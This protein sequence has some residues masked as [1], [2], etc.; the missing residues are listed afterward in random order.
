VLQG[1]IEL[2]N[3][4]VFAAAIVKK[5]RYWPNHINGHGI[6]T[7]FEGRDVGNTTA[8][9]GKLSGVSLNIMGLKQAPYVM[10]MMT[11]YGTLERTGYNTERRIG[12]CA[13]RQLVQFTYP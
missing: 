5:E 2:R 1:L 7:H 13:C 9:A 4:G 3:K 6:K 12:N 10:T 8:I 11:K